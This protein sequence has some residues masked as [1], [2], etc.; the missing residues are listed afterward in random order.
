MVFGSRQT[1]RRQGRRSVPGNRPTARARPRRRIATNAQFPSRLAASTPETPS[2]SLR[3]TITGF[4]SGAASGPARPAADPRQSR[5]AATE[6]HGH[7]SR[8]DVALTSNNEGPGYYPGPSTLYTERTSAF[9]RRGWLPPT[10]S[11]LASE[12]RPWSPTRASCR[13]AR[14]IVRVA[15][16]ASPSWSNS[17]SRV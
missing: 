16:R 6:G 13:C 9:P 4:S 8:R 1:S 17:T 15:A 12:R 2:S 5:R 7:R 3:M 11:A 10:Y 14:Q